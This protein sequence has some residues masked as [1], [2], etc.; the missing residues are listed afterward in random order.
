M[1]PEIFFSLIDLRSF[2]GFPVYLLSSCLDSSSPGSSQSQFIACKS[3]MKNHR[4]LK[5]DFETTCLKQ[6]FHIAP[7]PLTLLS[8]S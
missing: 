4:L 2:G 1:Y 3:P 6:P 5:E 8:F 7:S